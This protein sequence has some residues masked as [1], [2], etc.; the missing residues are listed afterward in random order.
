MLPRIPL[1]RMVGCSERHVL[2]FNVNSDGRVVE[3]KLMWVRWEAGG[4]CIHGYTHY[5][6]L[7]TYL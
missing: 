5:A 3:T 6:M 4:C 1:N 7:P 2:L